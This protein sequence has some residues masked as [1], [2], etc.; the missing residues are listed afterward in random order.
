[1][2]LPRFVA[3]RL[4][5]GRQHLKQHEHRPDH[6]QRKGERSAALDRA[7]QHAHGDRE[8]RREQ[9]AQ[10]QHD[11]PRD[12]ERAVGPGQDAEE[13][14]L[15]AIPQTLDHRRSLSLSATPVALSFDGHIDYA[16][17]ANGR[18]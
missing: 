7:N 17:V 14:P 3:D 6:G 18:L 16:R 4:M 13:L 11:P 1:M 15:L 5:E 8:Q 12:R 10:Q 9:S 2:R